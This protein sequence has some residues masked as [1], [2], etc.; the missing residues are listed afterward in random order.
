MLWSPNLPCR[1]HITGDSRP[2]RATV[3]ALSDIR[4]SVIWMFLGSM[5]CVSDTTSTVVAPRIHAT[6]SLVLVRCG[7]PVAARVREDLF[8]YV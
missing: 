6:C 7:V 5:L 8:E 4:R 3:R 2:D 1:Q